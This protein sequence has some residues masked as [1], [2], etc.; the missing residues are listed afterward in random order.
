MLC[1]RLVKALYG[2]L[3]SALLFYQKLSADLTRY[4]FKIN[5]YDPCLANK[6][7][8][9]GQLTVTRHVD[10]LKVS[11]EKEEVVTSFFK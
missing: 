8:N 11:H 9:G 10:D 3:K 5:P 4:G 1:V 6:L 2:C 7:V